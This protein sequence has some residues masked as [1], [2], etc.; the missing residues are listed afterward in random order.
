[1]SGAVPTTAFQQAFTITV[2]AEGGYVNNPNDPG[3]ETKYGISKR[4]YPNVD[5]KNLTLDQAEQLYK[6][7]YWD[8]AGCELCPPG[9]GICVFDAAVNNGVGMAVRWLQAA[10]G[11]TADGV[12][13]PQTQ[14]AIAGIADLPMVIGLMHGARINFMVGLNTWPTFGLG[15]SRRLA[16]IP[17]QAGMV[18]PQSTLGG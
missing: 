15:W 8:K 17:F 5:I 11:V 4:A 13:G 6:N 7:D 9:L 18:T 10:V 16:S 2:G 3:G 12:I 1:M 14:A